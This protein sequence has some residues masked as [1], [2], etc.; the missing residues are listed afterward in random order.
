M[1][2][3]EVLDE[4]MLTL[5]SQLSC[6]GPRSKINKGQQSLLLHFRPTAPQAKMVDTG[7]VEPRQPL[8]EE[9]ATLSGV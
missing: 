4:V 1:T 6:N 2:I 9:V 5:D 8:V 7:V 3:A